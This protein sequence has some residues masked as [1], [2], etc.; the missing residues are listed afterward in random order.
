[1][2]RRRAS[3]GGIRRPA[4]APEAEKTATPTEIHLQIVN[5]LYAENAELS[6]ADAGRYAAALVRAGVKISN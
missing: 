1:M 6:A 4:K 3:G 2:S 5:I